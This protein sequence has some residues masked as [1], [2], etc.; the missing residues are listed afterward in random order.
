[1]RIRYEDAIERARSIVPVAKKNVQLAEEMRRMPEENARAILDSGLMPLM[2]PKMFG[3]YE[4]DWM[5]QI[6]CVSEVARHCGS[7]GWCMTFFLQHH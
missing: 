4:A 3:G 7:T 2:R 5:T 1:M 6:D